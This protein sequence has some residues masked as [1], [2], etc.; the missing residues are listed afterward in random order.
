MKT[1]RRKGKGK[2]TIPMVLYILYST[3]VLMLAIREG[4]DPA[5]LRVV[6]VVWGSEVGRE[7]RSLLVTEDPELPL[8]LRT[9]ASAGATDNCWDTHT[10]YT[11]LHTYML[12]ESILC[13]STVV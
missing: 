13:H 12:S 1:T 3:L 2:S 4:T 11:V 7:R 5:V 9:R 10:Q 8:P 6:G